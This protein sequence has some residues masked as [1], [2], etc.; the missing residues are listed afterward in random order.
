MPGTFLTVVPNPSPSKPRRP[1]A[2]GTPTALVQ[3]RQI[4]LHPVGERPWEGRADDHRNRI[5]VE[6]HGDT[7]VVFKPSVGALSALNARDYLSFHV[8]IAANGDRAALARH[9]VQ[10]GETPRGAAI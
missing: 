4:R 8:F 2:R 9:F 3:N 5:N 1:L 6:Q 10:L 7:F